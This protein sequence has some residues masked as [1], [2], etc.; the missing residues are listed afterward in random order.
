MKCEQNSMISQLG[1]FRMET[2]KCT[3]VGNKHPPKKHKIYLVKLLYS[4]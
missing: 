3:K 2:H 1:H 4:V